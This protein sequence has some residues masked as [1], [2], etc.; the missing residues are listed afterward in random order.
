MPSKTR[1]GPWP[2]AIGLLVL[3]A[4]LGAFSTAAYVDARGLDYFSRDQVERHQAVI[5]GH[6]GNPWQYRVLAP[7]LVERI[8]A[9][10]APH[11][12]PERMATIFLVF[13]WL[14]DTSILLL[15]FA[16][17]GALGLPTAHRL[18]GMAMLAWGI[19]YSHY[20]SDMQFN[21]FFDVIFYLLAALCVIRQR[22]R[23][24][25]LIT[26]VAAFNRE[27]SGLMA[28][29]LL[30]VAMINEPRSPRVWWPAV[31]RVMPTMG[32]S[33]VVYAAVFLWLRMHFGAQELRIPYDHAPGPSLFLYNV[34][35]VITWQQLLATLSIVPIVALAYYRRWPD[36]LRV[37]FWV[38]VP[39]WCVV[40]AVG[41]VMAE[42]RLFL[43][44]Q[45]LVF[46]PGA[47]SALAVP[48]RTT[49]PG[50]P[51]RS[52]ATLPAS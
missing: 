35:R 7:Y 1:P 41:A 8:A 4:L 31:R 39:A 18:V 15:A 11:R 52:D 46:I 40:H 38:L 21:T 19:S 51:D 36:Q 12:Q 28:F 5:D 48:T 49:A 20:D 32:V 6:A 47:L 25:V 3:A 24:L 29:L 44:P 17:Y 42:A 50:L 13:R 2:R 33:L 9:R 43:V 45:A 26:L 23:W 37:F 16:Y 27:T 30:P 14:Q 10:V 34:A 22:W